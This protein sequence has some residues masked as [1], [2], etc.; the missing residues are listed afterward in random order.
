MPHNI[1]VFCAVAQLILSIVLS[2]LKGRAAA[3][4][5]A[6]HRY[7][8]GK[9]TG[10]VEGGGLDELDFHGDD[11]S[12]P[13]ALSAETVVD[14]SKRHDN[15]A[16]CTVQPSAG[17]SPQEAP[18]KPCRHLQLGPPPRRPRRLAEMSS[19]LNAVPEKQ[20]EIR[21]KNSAERHYS[22]EN[23]LTAV[24]HAANRRSCGVSLTKMNTRF[25]VTNERFSNHIKGA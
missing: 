22:Q 8:F 21:R 18:L 13:N 3:A 2:A 11:G 25:G 9:R 20:T 19:F 14:L 16:P 24:H 10:L 1:C 4:R 6:R 17:T 7:I 12:S 5:N 15:Y 23:A